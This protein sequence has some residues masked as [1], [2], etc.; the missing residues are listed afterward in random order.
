MWEFL[1]TA[2]EKGG[3]VG[4]AFALIFVMFGLTVR[5]LWNDNQDLH[6]KMGAIQEK[7]VEETKEVAETVLQNALELERAVDRLSAA[8]DTIM[9][10]RKRN[11]DQEI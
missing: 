9:R 10:L 2:L 5:T 7:R 11:D 6:A 3:L 4:L 8:L 1:G